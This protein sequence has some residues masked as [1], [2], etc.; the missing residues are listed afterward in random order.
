MAR[1]SAP[2]SSATSKHHVN[3]IWIFPNSKKQKKQ[4]KLDDE[5]VVQAVDNEKVQAGRL[6][7]VTYNS[8][9]SG[10]CAYAALGNCTQINTGNPLLLRVNDGSPSGSYVPNFRDRVNDLP[11]LDAMHQHL[12]LTCHIAGEH[13]PD[14]YTGMMSKNY[15]FQ[16]C[17]DDTSLIRQL[18]TIDDGEGGTVDT[19]LRVFDQLGDY[20]LRPGECLPHNRVVKLAIN[21]APH[22]AVCIF[23]RGHRIAFQNIPKQYLVVRLWVQ[24]NEGAEPE[25]HFVSFHQRGEY[26]Y[27]FGGERTARAFKIGE[28]FLARAFFEKT[29]ELL[30]LI[31]G[32]SWHHAS[33]TD[34]TNP[35]NEMAT[36]NVFVPKLFTRP[37]CRAW[38][39]MSFDEIGELGALLHP[40]IG[41][42]DDFPDEHKLAYRVVDLTLDRACVTD[43]DDV[44]GLFVP[45]V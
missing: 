21:T 40:V 17:G 9:V 43:G 15:F 16:V 33:W 7:F 3:N 5:K 18:V 36:F 13:G 39:D 23:D 6:V 30:N 34:P 35:G 38:D 24:A 10:N 44:L 45:S 28:R 29:E 27:G 26:F 11:D 20:R 14:N 2:R 4:K 41:A 32:D 19:D 37:V 42:A 25:P 8:D 12:T 1:A 31:A 22:H